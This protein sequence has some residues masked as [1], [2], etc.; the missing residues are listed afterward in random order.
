MTQTNNENQSNLTL[1][2]CSKQEE[3]SQSKTQLRKNQNLIRKFK[4]KNKK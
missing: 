2:L 4:V 3:I 1:D